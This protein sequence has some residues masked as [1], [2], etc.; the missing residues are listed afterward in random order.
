MTF[1]RDS[2]DYL[3]DDKAY[4]ILALFNRDTE[5]IDIID[6]NEIEYVYFD[7]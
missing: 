5:M 6:T 7:E 1:F 2:K 3:W 4:C